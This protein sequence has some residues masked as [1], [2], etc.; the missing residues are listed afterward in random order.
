MVESALSSSL[1]A[2]SVSVSRTTLVYI[3]NVIEERT[4]IDAL[5]FA[6]AE[7]RTVDS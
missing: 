1:S 3:S 7:R 4:V 6:L 5:S 2:L